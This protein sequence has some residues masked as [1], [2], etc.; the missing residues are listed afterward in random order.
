MD[1]NTK[2]MRFDYSFYRDVYCGILD[3]TLFS[4]F[5]PAACAVVSLL[6]GHDCEQTED[7]RVIRAMCLEC[8]CLERE[9]R[10]STGIKGE[11]LGDYSV[12]YTESDSCH[13]HVASCPVSGEVIASLT[14]AGL[15]TRWA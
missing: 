4:R 2:A 9:A 14:A 15:L 11:T 1:N 13:V 3:E 10:R 12:S 5:A 7:S 6:V 8:D